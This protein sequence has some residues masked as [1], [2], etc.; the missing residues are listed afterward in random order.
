MC[1]GVDGCMGGCMGA[2]AHAY[3]HILGTKTIVGMYVC[4]YI[5]SWSVRSAL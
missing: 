4:V 1:G 5:D 2:L 3:I